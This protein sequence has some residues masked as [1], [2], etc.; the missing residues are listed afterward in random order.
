MKQILRIPFDHLQL[1]YVN[2][3]LYLELPWFKLEAEIDNLE[4][5]NILLVMD[6]VKNKNYTNN[7]LQ[8]FLTQLSDYPISYFAPNDQS[9]ENFL[10]IKNFDEN[11][12]SITTDLIL[13][14]A[15]VK[16]YYFKK[17]LWDLDLLFST[18]KFSA[19]TVD[20]LSAVSY[21]IG[22][23]LELETI[24]ETYRQQINVKLEL[25][26]L[27]NESS[28][29]DVAA[30]L[31]RQ[32][33]FITNS[34]IRIL[35]I[36]SSSFL[37]LS[38][39]INNFINEEK[40]HHKLMEKS[41]YALGFRDVE[42]IEVISST[43]ELMSLFEFAA[44]NS[45]FAF[46]CFIGL[47]EGSFYSKSDPIADLL[48]R[49]SCPESGWGYKIHFSINQQHNHKDEIF[50]FARNLPALNYDDLEL[51]TRVFEI[52]A[53]I[54]QLMDIEI[55]NILDVKVANYFED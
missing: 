10:Y 32:T 53:R 50:K 38:E 18:C 35:T 37:F 13:K 41:I 45:P 47:F 33:H 6:S 7:A 4:H 3:T 15:N 31:L 34:V 8:N 2:S 19:Y 49:S 48:S 27:Y 39:P 51:G 9:A 36:A 54:S 16:Q 44:M 42:Q 23:R 29:L 14:Q 17:W 26:A 28:M 43:R 20:P 24:T 21:L 40:T 12:K 5:N 46:C 30:V 52:G 1:K 55:N 11:R 25:L 22:K